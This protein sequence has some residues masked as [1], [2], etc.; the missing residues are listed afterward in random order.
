[1]VPAW[2]TEKAENSCRIFKKDISFKQPM[3]YIITLL[4]MIAQNLLHILSKGKTKC[5]KFRACLGIL[6]HF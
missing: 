6:V 4:D 5:A 1:M 2:P 3:S